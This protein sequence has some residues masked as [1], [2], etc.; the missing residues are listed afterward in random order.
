MKKNIFS[1]ES[2]HVIPVEKDIEIGS[3][4]VLFSPFEIEVITSS[5]FNSYIMKDNIAVS[6]IAN[7]EDYYAYGEF[8]FGPLSR[9]SDIKCKD[10]IIHI[11]D[12]IHKLSEKEVLELLKYLKVGNIQYD[13]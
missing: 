7:L 12:K 3:L 9:Y 11:I 2:T 13:F 10:I 1:A 4:K 6:I 5:L 8:I